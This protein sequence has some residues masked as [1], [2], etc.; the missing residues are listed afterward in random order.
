MMA[1][2]GIWNL[3]LNMASK[4]SQVLKYFYKFYRLLPLSEMMGGKD[5]KKNI[6]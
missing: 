4:A 3:Q 2:A 6:P 1:M 5:M